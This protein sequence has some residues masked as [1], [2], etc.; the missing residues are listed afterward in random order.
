MFPVNYIAQR[1]TI[2]TLALIPAIALAGPI[3]TLIPAPVPAPDSEFRLVLIEENP[4]LSIDGRD[5]HYTNGNQISLLSPILQNGS[6]IDMPF[7]WLEQNTFLFIKPG[8]TTDNRLEWLILGQAIFTPQDHHLSNPSTS[9]RPYAG[10]LFTG[11]NLIQNQDE[12]VL[13]SLELQ[14]GV[15]GSWALGHQIQ[16]SFH[17]LLGDSLARGWGHQLGNQFGFVVTWNRDWRFDHQ[18]R[19]GYSWELIPTV[20]L[21]AGDVYTYG[22]AGG[23]VRWGL[24]LNA[25]WGPDLFPGP[26]YPG[27]AY[28][29]P[30]RT[31]TRWGFDFYGGAVGRLMAVNVFLDGN[32]LQNSRSVAETVPV[33]DLL[34]GA[35]FFFQDRF[36][37]GFTAILRSPEFRE[38]HGPDSFGGVTASFNF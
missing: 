29:D 18:L 12:H 16:N 6:W 22:Q 2:S 11:L 20:G 34:I 14:A 26:G 4:A 31:K 9:D 3:D 27:T 21:A 10:W 28:F 24:G 38:Q 7:R 33:G 17:A 30:K 35:E 15:V 32:T 8:E 37:I 5:R 1:L 25:T 36:R 19:N 23:I 13:T